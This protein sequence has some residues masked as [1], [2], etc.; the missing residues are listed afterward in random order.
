MSDAVLDA[1]SDAVQVTHL[2]RTW[3]KY[4]LTLGHSVSTTSPQYMV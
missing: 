1:V 4:Y 2:A 3:C